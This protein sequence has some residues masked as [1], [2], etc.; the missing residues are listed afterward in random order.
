[1]PVAPGVAPF[2]ASSSLSAN[3]MIPFVAP[4]K[5]FTLTMIGFPFAELVSYLWRG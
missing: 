4:A 2:V 3:L 5:F 1:M